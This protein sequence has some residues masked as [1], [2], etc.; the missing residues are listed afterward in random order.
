MITH[1]DVLV[2]GSGPVGISVARRL[3]ERGLQVTVLE[4][5]EA[6]TDPPGSHFRNQDRIQADPD[7]YF[8]AIGPYLQPV[9]GAGEETDLPGAADSSLVGGQGILWT[10]NCPR[11]AEFERWEA[12]T[13]SEWD[14]RYEEAEDILQV[15]IDPSGN[16]KVGQKVRER[17]HMALADKRRSISQLPFSGR[18][19]PSGK[20]YYN[21]PS[22]ILAAAAPEVQDRIT[23]RSS[24]RVSRLRL[25]GSR[26]TGVELQGNDRGGDFLEASSVFLAGGAIA[27]PQLLHR[28]G[29][30]PE[31]LGRGISFHALMFGQVI[32]EAE[33]CPSVSQPDIDSRLWIPPTTDSPWHLMVLR[34]TCPLPPAEEVDNPHRLVELQA[35]LPVEFQ[36]ENAFVFDEKEGPAFRFTFSQN[37]REGM[38]AMEADVQRLA[39]HLGRWRRGCECTWMPHGSAHV[40]GTCRMDRPGW[41][42]VAD[43]VGKVH[44]FDN[45]YL[46]SVGVFPARV[47]ENPTLTAVAL[48]LRLCDRFVS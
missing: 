31:A 8:G 26:V 46:A 19:L 10:N 20:L 11:A 28:S 45:L 3:S 22:D 14:R 7:G 16:S 4:A 17:L 47:A 33:L 42:G 21:G 5:G 44:G 2:V 40:V 48:A 23:I 27:I 41:K 38:Q 12:M 34:D 30:R 35:F 13:P 36:D 25:Q 18:I 32:L 6:I 43:T 9:I 37:D 1:Q 29:I 24:V 39:A 15:V